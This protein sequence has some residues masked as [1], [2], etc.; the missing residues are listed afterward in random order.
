MRTPVA[1]IAALAVVALSGCSS[2]P[3][4]AQGS[5]RAIDYLHDDVAAALIAFDLPAS[6]EPVEDG[7]T[8]RIDLDA[9]SG[10]RHV[11]V[12]LQRSGDGE[13]AGTL[14]P[15]AGGRSYYLF[16]F[17]DA[18]AGAIRDAQAFARSLPQ[19]AAGL[20]VIL[21]PALCR[22]GPVD[23]DSVRVSVRVAI[24]GAPALAAPIQDQPLTVV[25][26]GASVPACR[27]HSG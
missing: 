8:L 1:A 27:G 16:G 21:A 6:L 2:L 19:G 10:G 3:I 13:L 4:G 14:P 22:I 9:P 23:P 26:G 7:S 18:D 5:A 24:P 11:R 15:P 12:V 25:T 17:S 20:E